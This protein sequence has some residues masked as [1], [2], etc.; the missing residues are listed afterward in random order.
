LDTTS[1]AVIYLAMTRLLLR[2]S[3]AHEPL[4]HS[5]ISREGETTC[6]SSV[7]RDLAPEQPEGIL[8]QPTRIAGIDGGHRFLLTVGVD[9]A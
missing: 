2:R 7:L 9:N 4:S 6:A 5:P 8:G 1:V 3:P